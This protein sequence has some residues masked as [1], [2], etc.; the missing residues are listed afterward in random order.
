MDEIRPHQVYTTEE[1]RSFLRISER[2]MK[3]WLKR[4]IIRANKIG[5]R[6]RIMGAELLA[7]VSPEVERKA[8]GA[9]KRLKKKVQEKIS[10]W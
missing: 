6:Y 7:L 3:R 10:L 8:E 5:S 2:T 4:G 9:Y 1:A